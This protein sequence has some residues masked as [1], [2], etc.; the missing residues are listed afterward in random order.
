MHASVFDEI[1]QKRRSNRKFD[2]KAEVPAAVVRNSLERAILSPNSSNMQLWEF[3][4]VSSADMK[5]Q[6]IPLCLGQNAAKTASHLV[7]FLTRQDLWKKHAKWNL[8]ETPETAA[9]DA[10]QKRVRLMKAYYGKLMPLVYGQDPFGIFTGVRKL[11]SFFVGLTMPFMRFGGKGDQRV[12]LHKSCALAA[13]TFMLSITAEGYDTCPMEGFDRVRLARL[14]DLPKGAEICMVV[15]V[16]KGTE[17]GI[18]GERKRLAFEDV[19]RT[20]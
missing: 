18:Y 5:Q 4:W 13:Q 9:T 10:D 17:A 11:T 12:I 6:M 2:T 8:Q 1:V 14:L 7:V 19:V 16:G 15:A 20:I 3:I